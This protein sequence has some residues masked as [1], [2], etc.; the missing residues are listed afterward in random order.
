M[1]IY[2]KLAMSG[3]SEE[4]KYLHDRTNGDIYNTMTFIENIGYIV[5][6]V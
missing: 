3:K 5:H 1:D 6:K 2:I 4:D